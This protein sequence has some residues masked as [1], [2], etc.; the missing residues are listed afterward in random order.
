MK[1]IKFIFFLFSLIISSHSFADA[2][3]YYPT[4]AS[5]SQHPLP[6]WYQDAKFGVLIHYGIYDIPA[7]A[8]LLNPVGKILT[9][10]FFYTNPYSEWYLNTM[11]IKGSP[12]YF[13]HLLTYGAEFDYKNFAPLFNQELEKWK[14]DQWSKLFSTAGVKYAVLTSRHHD[15]FLMWP[16]QYRNPYFPNYIA[17]RDVVGEFVT[18]IRRF[19]MHPGIYYSG[20]FDWTFESE[21]NGPITNVIQGLQK[22]PQSQIYVDYIDNQLHELIAKYHPDVLWNDVAL[23]K[24]FQKWRL[25]ADYYNTV[26]EGVLNNRWTQ[27]AFDFTMLGQVPDELLDLQ[28]TYDWFDYYTC[29]FATSTRFTRHKWE[30]THGTGYS[31]SYNQVEYQYPEHF[32]TADELIADLADIV[33]KNGNLLLGIGPKA[34]GSF[35]ELLEKLL[36]NMGDWLRLN[37]EAIY[38]TIP[39]TTQE[40]IAQPVNIP[41]RFTQSKDKKYIYAILL[42]NPLNNDISISHFVNQ[43]KTIDVLNGNNPI[44]VSWKFIGDDLKVFLKDAPRIPHEHPLVLRIS[45]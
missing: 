7:W 38:A 37:G 4:Q 28:M 36:L 15:G 16:S 12:T 20:G 17:A 1:K 8:P 34:D 27:D 26:P 43:V 6:E 13:H 9:R 5:V 39:W 18:S 44:P 21:Y 29:E 2:N 11:Q 24:K 40:G 41:I 31:F 32:K 45:R 19:G 30:G 25:F 42:K 10:E 22:I 23:P 33:S 3:K 35:P 14:P